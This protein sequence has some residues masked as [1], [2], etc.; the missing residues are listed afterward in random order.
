MKLIPFCFHGLVIH[1]ANLLSMF[2]VTTLARWISL[3]ANVASKQL[4]GLCSSI[5][6]TAKCFATQR[7]LINFALLASRLTRA[8]QRQ[9]VQCEKC[10]R[11][12]SCGRPN[13]QKRKEK[14]LRESNYNLCVDFHGNCWLLSF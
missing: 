2:E 6:V 8:N 14:E 7:D 1:F 9:K 4:P 13:L 10:H 5:G 11:D 12:L 3:T